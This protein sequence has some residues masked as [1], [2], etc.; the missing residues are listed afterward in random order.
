MKLFYISSLSHLIW[1][2]LVRMTAI[3]SFTDNLVCG[4]PESKEDEL[5]KI[6]F[7]FLCVNVAVFVPS[8]FE[9]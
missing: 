2:P 1:F 9:A 8:T 6:E 4:I 5:L 7:L 3:C